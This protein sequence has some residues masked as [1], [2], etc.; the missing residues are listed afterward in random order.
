MESAPI[1]RATI[2]ILNVKDHLE[3]VLHLESRLQLIYRIFSN[4]NLIRKVGNTVQT[5][6]Q[7]TLL[8]FGN[9]FSPRHFF[10]T[11]WR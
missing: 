7:N 2:N 1:N 9:I 6:G 10:N 8:I 4:A 11:A 5:G 3:F